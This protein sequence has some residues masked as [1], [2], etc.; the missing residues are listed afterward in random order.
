M[1]KRRC[2]YAF[3]KNDEKVAIESKQAELHQ[4]KK[5][6]V[7]IVKISVISSPVILSEPTPI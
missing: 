2:M 3:E 1:L 7:G 5:E 6:I 4:P